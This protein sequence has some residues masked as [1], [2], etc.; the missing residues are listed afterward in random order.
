VTAYAFLGRPVP[1][2]F[3]V[4]EVVVAPGDDLAYVESDWCGCIVTVESGT[5]DL[6]SPHSVR[7][8]FLTGDILWLAGL[9]VRALENP[10]PDPTVLVAISRVRNSE[11][12]EFPDPAQSKGA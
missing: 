4:R 8:S 2:G 12:D 10:G 9:P 6:A 7:A 3:V 1:P 11:A 5:I